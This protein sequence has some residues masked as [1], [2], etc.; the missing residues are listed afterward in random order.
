M[1]PYFHPRIEINQILRPVSNLKQL[2]LRI[3]WKFHLL[4][5]R[6]KTFLK[7]ST[8]LYKDLPEIE[9]RILIHIPFALKSIPRQ[10]ECTTNLETIHGKS[11]L[12]SGRLR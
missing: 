1:Y 11:L 6:E 9:T 2:T 4:S 7:I 8:R 12:I 3:N 10:L 5:L